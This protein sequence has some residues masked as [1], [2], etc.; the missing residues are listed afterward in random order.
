MAGEALQHVE[1]VVHAL[2]LAGALEP[3][4][5]AAGDLAM[6]MIGRGVTTAPV[7]VVEIDDASIAG[8][9]P[10]PWPRSSIAAIVTASRDAGAAAVIV[11]LLLTDPGPEEGDRDLATAIGAGPAIVAA[12]I[13]PDGGW[14]L[15][16]ARFGGAARAAHVHVEVAADGVA[17]TIVATKQAAGLSLP[18]ISL[19]AARV[20]RPDLEI[21]PGLPLRPDFRP[22]PSRI[23]RVPAAGLL[24]GPGPAGSL[25]G[26][27]V[28]VGVT[29]TGAGDRLVVPTDPGPAP[30]PGVL[31]H[32]SATASI[33]RGG[34]VRPAGIGWVLGGSL[35]AALGASSFAMM[36]AGRLLLPVAPLA[37]APVIAV[38]LREAAESRATRR[39]SAVLLES[40]LAHLRAELPGRPPTSAVA[41]LE[42]LRE[43]QA[44]VLRED[45]ARRA[46]LDAMADGV[47]MWDRQGVVLIANP[48]ARR[49]WGGDPAVADLE[50]AAAGRS[51]FV[52]RPGRELAVS[53][54]D[55]EPGGLAILRD[56]TAERE[57]ER[58]R[59]DMQRLVS[60]E[61]KTPLASIAGL[62]ETMERF[63]LARDEQRRVA[64]LIR[65]ES[66]RLGAM[67]AT[68]LDLERL[69][70]GGWEL[71][72]DP[73]DL[74]TLV[75]ERLE[76]LGETARSRGQRVSRRLGA[77]PPVRV[78]PI[79][80]ARVVDNLVGNALA[81]SPDGAEVEVG[82][83]RADDDAVL[84][85]ADHGPGIPAEA[86]PHLFERF[87]RV[88][89]TARP[90]SGL[91]LAV[92]HE[93]V[94][95]HGGCI[96]V[97]STVGRGTTFTVRLPGEV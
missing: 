80:L 43:L 87:Y 37:L 88:P 72:E 1:V 92:A 61:L 82:V 77:C 6:R 81:Y 23:V 67:V 19:A 26:R 56:V 44:A 21:R 54:V 84:T 38:V 96:T 85:V 55:L 8:V 2:W 97:D 86:I 62:G 79:L 24:G 95:W 14:V 13:A 83:A 57:L 53:A 75:A 68:F 64:A 70:S 15:P 71:P 49:L 17:R 63:E 7:A 94:T 42:A 22:D 3:V 66:T 52:Q 73:V 50:A 9:G 76:V 20:L 31:V 39:E 46:L 32:A 60:H 78:S 58:R 59:R 18:A 40:L 28:F 65:T 34:L 93:V 30:S 27:L 11:D 10:L 12:A 36:A 25:A 16:H 47:V 29:A 41:S 74:A 5:R 45:G 33:L 91:G 35:L 51:A 69:G 89:G 90:G 4:D 48:A